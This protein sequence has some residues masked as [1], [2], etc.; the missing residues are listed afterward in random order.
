LERARHEA[1]HASV[2]EQL[3]LESQIA[4]LS[5]RPAEAEARKQRAISMAEQTRKG[6]G[7]IVSNIG[8]FG[9]GAFKTGMARRLEP[10]DRIRELGEAPVPFEFDVHARI[11]SD[12]APA[13]ER[14]LHEEF[15]DCRINQVNYRKELFRLPLERLR[16]CLTARGIEISLTMLAEAYEFRETQALLKMTPEQREKYHLRRDEGGDGPGDS[17]ESRD[18]VCY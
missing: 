8:S 2:E 1:A 6:T 5:P 14:M 17:F 4:E 13:L 3:K 12:D 11:P 9:E 10:D 16:S 18:F 15:D 7:Y